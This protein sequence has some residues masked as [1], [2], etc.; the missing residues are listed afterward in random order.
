MTPITISLL[1][2]ALPK[3][4][5]HKI[6]K[7]GRSRRVVGDLT[8]VLA[9]S[10]ESFGLLALS[11]TPMAQRDDLPWSCPIE[12]HVTFVYTCAEGWPQWKKDAALLE[13]DEGRWLYDK[14]PDVENVAKFVYDALEGLFYT[15]DK[16]IFRQVMEKR[17]GPEE[18]VIVTLIPHE[19]PSKPKKAKK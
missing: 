15:N 2:R 3:A 13:G 19:Q 7:R 12:A 9:K 4:N 18:R 16:L 8:G 11:L 1:Y 10:E 5:M 14:T 6:A 17:F